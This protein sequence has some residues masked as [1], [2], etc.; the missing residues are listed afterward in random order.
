MEE[1]IAR[2]LK[3][4]AVAVGGAILTVVTALIVKEIIDR[5]KIRE[6]MLKADMRKAIVQQINRSKSTIKLD[7]LESDKV[8]E[9]KGE[10]IA[11]DIKEGEV[12]YV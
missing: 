12:I 9:L 2:L 1:I 10:K 11:D 5:K 4:A 7:D 3:G 8:L 6:E